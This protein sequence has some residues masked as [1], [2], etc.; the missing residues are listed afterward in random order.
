MEAAGDRYKY[1]KIITPT[2]KNIYNSIC[3]ECKVNCHMNCKL[4]F[5]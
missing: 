5:S 1:M 3:T 2:D 4:D